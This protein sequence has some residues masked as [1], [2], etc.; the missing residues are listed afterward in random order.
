MYVFDPGIQ[1]LPRQKAKRRSAFAPVSL[2]IHYPNFSGDSAPSQLMTVTALFRLRP[3]TK[4]RRCFISSAPVPFTRY[5]LPPGILRTT[6]HV[7]NLY[8]PFIRHSASAVI[9]FN[10]PPLYTGVN[11]FHI[12]FLSYAINSACRL[13]TK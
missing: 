4:R 11:F 8:R 5:L 2:K 12:F 7:R 3:E 13:L 9:K 1:A 10:I 6:H